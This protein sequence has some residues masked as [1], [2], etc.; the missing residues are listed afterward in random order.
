[1][2]AI[3]PVFFLSLLPTARV[4]TDTIAGTRIVCSNRL[5]VSIICDHPMAIL[6]SSIRRI[7]KPTS[8]PTTL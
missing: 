5:F 8:M 3:Q 1:M 7:V 6:A 4:R 2:N